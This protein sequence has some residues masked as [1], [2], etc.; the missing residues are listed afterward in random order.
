MKLSEELE[1]MAKLEEEYAIRLDKDFRG[2]G[3][4]AVDALIETIA[5]DSKKHAILYRTAAY[6]IEEKSLALID[7]QLEDLEKRLKKH[8]E[9]E[10]EMIEKASKYADEVDNVGA[11]NILREIYMDE[12]RHHPFMKNLL[13]LVLKAET[14]TEEDVFNLV[15]RDLPTGGAPD[16]IFE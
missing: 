11:K 5:L 9:V 13:E 6:L 8:I 15:F 10:K 7:I 12:V 2:W 14:I 4:P 3:N 1:N 16:P